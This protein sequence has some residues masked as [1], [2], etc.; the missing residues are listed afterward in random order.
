MSCIAQHLSNVYRALG[1]K[2]PAALSR[3]ILQ[4][5]AG[6][7]REAPS[8]PI[9]ATIDGEVTSYFEWLGAGRYRPDTRSG[10]MHGGGPPVREIFYGTDGEHL[11]VRLD[12]DVTSGFGI[13]FDTC[14]AMVQVA[15]GRIVEISA[16]L[17][18]H[19]FRVTIAQDELPAKWC[20]RRGGLRFNRGHASLAPCFRAR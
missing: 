7:F 11:Y 20:P 14:R 18:G 9:H 3:P 17:V 8:N 2:P 10:S 16:R 19:R 1:L 13:E 5:H 6:E 15:V 12:S 4:S